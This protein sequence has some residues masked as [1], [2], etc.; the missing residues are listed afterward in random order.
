MMKK[1]MLPTDFSENAEN[2]MLYALNLFKGE[3]CA[4][5]LLNTYLPSAQYEEHY[6][7]HTDIE[8]SSSQKSMK[9]LM[10]ISRRLRKQFN[11][12]K[13]MFVPHS[14][15]NTV[16]GELKKTVEKE[17]I[18]LVIM[19]TQGVTGAKDIVFGSNTTQTIKKIDRP[20]IAVPSDFV[21]RPPKNILF[22][23]DY[24]ITYS[25]KQLK[26]LLYIAES[27]GS[28]ISV[29][30]VLS[31]SGLTEHQLANKSMLEKVLQGTNHQIH[32]VSGENVQSTIHD[33]Q[34]SGDI[35]FLVM[36]QN[37]HTFMESLFV[38]SEIK[39]IG[40][41]VKIPFMA[42]PFLPKN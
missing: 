29:L 35:D 28:H 30:H 9:K 18:D 10:A 8:D 38:R 19:G 40:L 13:H 16:V 17:D 7:W 33:W 31:P 21:Y 12:Q 24:E 20:I 36:V 5:Y 39:Q 34:A 23:T 11:N 42:I 3:E 2:A 25:E 6:P 1:I 32:H 37:K 15:M 4:F 14:A 27:Y 22:P 41:R 26:T